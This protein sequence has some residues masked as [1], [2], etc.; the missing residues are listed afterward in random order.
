[1][2]VYFSVFSETSFGFFGLHIFFYKKT[3]YKKTQPQICQHLK[4]S[5]RKSP[6]SVAPK[7]SIFFNGKNQIVFKWDAKCNGTRELKE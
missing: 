7:L 5:L 2:F 4:K 6:A 3:V 1:M